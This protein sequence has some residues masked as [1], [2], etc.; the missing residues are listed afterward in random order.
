MAVERFTRS[1]TRLDGERL[2]RFP[3]ASLV[4]YTA[5]LGGDGAITRFESASVPLATDS[6]S[7]SSTVVF[8]MDSVRVTLSTGDSTRAYA[9][10]PSVA[11]ASIFLPFSF[12]LYE[13]LVRRTIGRGA[14]SAV[15]ELVFPGVFNPLP[16]SVRRLAADSVAIDFFGAPLRARID[17][18][19]RILGVDGSATTQKVTVTRERRA[20]VGALARA[21]AAS[22]RSGGAPGQLSSRDTIHATVDGADIQIDYGR[23][24]ARGRTIMGELVPWNEVWRTGA[25]AATGFITSADLLIGG[26]EVP[27]GSYT[28]YS[29]PR[30]DGADL[31]VNR[32]TGQWGTEYDPA[33]DLARIPLVRRVLEV[34]VE[35]FT[36][37]LDSTGAGTVLRLAWERTEWTA[38]VTPR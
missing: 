33:L 11:E 30:P 20:D 24:R 15:A 38:A 28:L 23:P 35:Q 26:V 1:A 12:A 13:Q 9:M 14:D 3:R 10:N 19:G 31:I 18:V 4:R 8:G 29:L 16:T 27:A 6:S 37:A 25:N 21:F 22:E 36:I 5:T 7:A 34:P 32:Q 2:L 17:R